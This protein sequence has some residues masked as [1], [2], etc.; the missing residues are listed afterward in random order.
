MPRWDVAGRY[1]RPV[2]STLSS[3][4]RKGWRNEDEDEYDEDDDGFDAFMGTASNWRFMYTSYFH[5]QL[6][7]QI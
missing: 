6:I 7:N 4:W 5:F 2:G 1:L 3:P